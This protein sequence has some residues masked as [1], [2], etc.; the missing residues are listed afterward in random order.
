MALI[1]PGVEV[2]V[3]DESQYTPTAAGTVAYVL[4]ASAENKQTPGGALAEYTT[5]ATAGQLQSITSQRDLVQKFGVPTFQVDASDN[6]I[7]GDER[8]EYGLQAAYS[9]LG[10][11]N[12]LYVQRADIDLAQLQGTGI[13]PT[14]TANDGTYWLD[15]SNTNWGQ[16]EWNPTN[17][18]GIEEPL[19]IT[20]QEQVDENLAPISSVGA[21]WATAVVPIS[22]SNKMYYK[23]EDNAWV[24]IGS[25]DWRDSIPTVVGTITDPDDL[26]GG[27][28]MYINN[29]EVTLS[30]TGPVTLQDVVD[31]INAA[32]ITG[33]RADLYPL[34]GP[35]QVIRIFSNSTSV[36]ED[37]FGDPPDDSEDFGL[38]IQK[39]GTN[40]NFPDSIGDDD[41]SEKIGLIDPD[42]AN[43][44]YIWGPTIQFSGFRNVPAWKSTDEVPRPYTSTWFKTSATGNGANWSVKQYNEILDQWVPQA[45]PLYADDN[46]AILDLDP[47]GGGG[48]LA[49]GSLYVQ[50]DTQGDNTATF[51]LFRKNSIGVLKITGSTPSDPL[52]FTIGNRFTIEVSAPGS[53]NT[54]NATIILSGTTAQSFV[55]NILSANIPNLIAAVEASGAISVSHL[56][57]GTI[58]FSKV[59]GQGDPLTTS[60]LLADNKV[61]QLFDDNTN[62]YLA[63][64]FSPLTYTYSTVAPFSNPA[65]GTL[66]YFNNPL[67]V[68][69]MIN[70]GA[71]W[72]GYGNVANDARGYNLT[73]TD[74]SGVILSASRPVYQA[75]GTTPVVP[76]ELWIDTG[77]LENYPVI[78]RYTGATWELIDNKDQVS[79]DGILF[80]DARW[81]F[82]GQSNPIVD[83]LP[84]IASMRTN[85]YIDDDC[86]DYRLYA[87][88]TLLFNTRRSGYNVKRFE[89]T[90]FED[91]DTF[92]GDV[93]PTNISA[94]VSHSGVDSDG[95]PY[96]GH[97]AQRNT[98]VEAMKAA[99]ESSTELREENTQFNL[100]VCPG[101]PELIQNM[102]TLNNDRKQTAFIIGDSPLALNSSDIESW[103]KNTAL[104]LDN[105]PNGLV[106]TSEYLGVY[107]PAGFSTS[108]DGESVVVPPSHMMLRTFIRSDNVSYPWFAPAGV[109]RGV[110]DNATS[111]G[112]ID[113]N[114]GNIFRSIGVTVGLRDIMY[115]N[116]VNP[117]TVLPG[118]GLVAYGQKT[119]AAFTSAMDR[120]N[121]ARLVVYLRLVLDKVARPFIFEPNDTITRNQ[122][123][124]AFE[125]VLNDVVAKRGLYDYLVVCDTTNNTPDRIDRNE[126]YI[127]I[128]IKP[129]KAIEF[130]YIPVRIRN[131]GA[132][133]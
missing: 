49:A 3:I 73:N 2:T 100:I 101:Y 65:D 44:R 19:V 132:E 89:S 128:A 109:R 76:G 55:A 53:A 23:N 93:E 71:G 40:A 97:W 131:T 63:S 22:N 13:R 36:P 69:I 31:D 17:T 95:V 30:G 41:F 66:W 38:K 35:G 62:V 118:V 60:G 87:R 42:G 106:S 43:V 33:V 108:L 32:G 92:F 102:I 54:F 103:T 111:I 15:L 82:N 50:Y 68:D 115:D 112:Y 11:A 56:A 79:T 117:L 83:D 94:W 25:E 110:I 119:R 10:V 114:D 116:R 98:I 59:S 6:P 67:E 57:G 81:D 12:R 113:V 45:A 99:I 24:E 75:D 133:L 39:G 16:Y 9:A 61:R 96:F 48:S 85:N 58:K 27:A 105:G 34:T 21:V 91:P 122:V 46:A 120:V 80:A 5:K 64:P 130:V 126:L 123:K 129:V 20:D 124:S 4:V 121:V 72:K 104:A 8:N 18:F 77:D 86:P 88:G 125:S 90:W 1:S 29:V 26:E 127:D 47:A 37:F 14:G 78:Y 51:K 70:D 7:H 84:S 74:P 28:S 52:T 107:Y